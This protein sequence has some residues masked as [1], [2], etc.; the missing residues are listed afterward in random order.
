MVE[1]DTGHMEARVTSAMIDFL[2]PGET[3]NIIAKLADPAI[4]I[5]SMTITEGG[6]FIDAS[7]G[8]STRS[9][10]RLSPTG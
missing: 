10:R 8:S 4:R 6:Y 9:I 1:Q 7:T 5:V 3:E 2:V